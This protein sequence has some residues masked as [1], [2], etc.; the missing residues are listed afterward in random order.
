MEYPLYLTRSQVEE[1]Q[2]EFLPIG[3]KLK[4]TRM[5]RPRESEYEDPIYWQN[6]MI[7]RARTIC[8]LPVYVLRSDDLGEYLPQ[9]RVWH[10]GEF[11]ACIRR[12]DATQF[13]EF[14]TEL[15][16]RD[17]I[18]LDEANELLALA[19]S[20]AVIERSW[21][22]DVSVTVSP[23]AGDE[24]EGEELTN[25]RTLVARMDRDLAAQDYAAVVHCSASIFE[26]LAKDVVP[27]ST[28]KTQTL[29]SFFDLYRKE[30]QLPEPVLD[31]VETIYAN[32]NTVPL[33]GHGQVIPPS[34]TRE[35]AVTLAHMTKAFL[36]IERELQREEA[37]DQGIGNRDEA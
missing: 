33:A 12:L 4:L 21:Q 8:G 32:R 36:R 35:E 6:R 3:V 30:S 10:E 5:L 13:L 27:R 24:S 7:N 31:Y 37:L 22:G 28:V 34:V 26:T 11:E 18:E 16:D 9:E 29:G 23:L 17:D 14:L 25:I 15:V 1:L 19:D 20:S 2:Y